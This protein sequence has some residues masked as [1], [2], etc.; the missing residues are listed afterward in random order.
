MPA[1]EFKFNS[2]K[3]SRAPKAFWNTYPNALFQIITL[4]NYLPFVGIFCRDNTTI[5]RISHTTATTADFF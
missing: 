3:M 1:Y 2:N 4:D 5:S